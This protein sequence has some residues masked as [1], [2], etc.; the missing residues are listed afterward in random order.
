MKPSARFLSLVSKSLILKHCPSAVGIQFD[1]EG[2]QYRYCLNAGKTAKI[3]VS[4]ESLHGRKNFFQF[5]RPDGRLVAV[6]WDGN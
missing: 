3:V 6:F 1:Y 5:F 2:Q 4:G